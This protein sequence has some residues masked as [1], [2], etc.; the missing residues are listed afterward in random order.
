[1]MT[2]EKPYRKTEDTQNPEGTAEVSEPSVSFPHLLT[3]THPNSSSFLGDSASNFIEKIETTRTDPQKVTP[4]HGPTTDVSMHLMVPPRFQTFKK[5]RNRLLKVKAKRL[6]WLTKFFITWVPL[7]DLSSLE[8]HSPL[9]LIP[10]QC[11]LAVSLNTLSTLLCHS[12]RSYCNG[13]TFL[14]R[15]GCR[16]SSKALVQCH[17]YNEVFPD[18][19]V[20]MEN[21]F[22]LC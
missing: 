21:L 5:G 1:M 13:D 7:V 11:L 15:A 8:L 14:Q 3:L 20:S 6:Q 16:T 17:L 10:A 12:P 19:S 18:Y 4:S 9:T 2:Q 22:L